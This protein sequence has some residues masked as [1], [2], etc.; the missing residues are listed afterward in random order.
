[1]LY[2]PDVVYIQIPARWLWGCDGLHAGLAG[3]ARCRSSGLRCAWLQH[4]WRLCQPVQTSTQATPVSG[5]RKTPPPQTPDATKP[6]EWNKQRG[7]G[8]FSAWQAGA[9]PVRQGTGEALG[10]QLQI[11]EGALSRSQWNSGDLRCLYNFRR[12]LGSLQNSACQTDNFLENIQPSTQGPSPVNPYH[13]DCA[14]RG[15]FRHSGDML[16]AWDGLGSGG[17]RTSWR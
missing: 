14:K 7:A 6:A 15:V 16:L 1:M 4:L 8:Y 11:Y 17:P 3:Q 2:L 13:L 10:C 12:L 9:Y 5:C